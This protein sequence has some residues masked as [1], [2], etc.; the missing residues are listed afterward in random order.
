LNGREMKGG[1]VLNMKVYVTKYAL[2]DGISEYNNFC[3]SST[4]QIQVINE[5]GYEEY[6]HLNDCHFIREDAIRRANEKKECEIEKLKKQLD[7]V[8]ALEF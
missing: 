6:Y 2:S 5:D 4:G 7:K 1:I 3:V 8:K